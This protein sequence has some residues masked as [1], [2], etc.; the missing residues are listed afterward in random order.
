MLNDWAHDILSAKPIESMRWNC[1]R[2][3]NRESDAYDSMVYVSL[4]ATCWS[5]FIVI[6]RSNTSAG[7]DL[8][9]DLHWLIGKWVAD[10]L[11]ITSEKEY[12]RI[13]VLASIN[14]AVWHVC[15]THKHIVNAFQLDFYSWIWVNR[16]CHKNE[17]IAQNTNN[18]NV[19]IYA[20][21][22]AIRQKLI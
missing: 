2:D 5:Y 18:T 22:F 17:F 15:M 12:L 9:Q 21:S 11:L 8:V 1:K 16:M 3:R 20:I 14:C 6:F 19:N 7:T 10:W 4:C 13:W